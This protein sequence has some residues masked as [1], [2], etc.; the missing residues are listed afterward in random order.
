MVQHRFIKQDFF[1]EAIEI[2]GHDE[3]FAKLVAYP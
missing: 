1:F 3:P 2:D